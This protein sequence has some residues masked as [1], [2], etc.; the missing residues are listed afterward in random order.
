MAKEEIA[1]FEQFLLLSQCF[2]KSSAAKVSKNVCIRERVQISNKDTKMHK[3]VNFQPFIRQR[4]LPC[5]E[6]GLHDVYQYIE[7]VL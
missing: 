6:H 4:I 1:C 7:I 2:Q 3:P 5:L